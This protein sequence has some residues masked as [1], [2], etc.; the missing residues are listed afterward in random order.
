[1]DRSSGLESRV[2]VSVYLVSSSLNTH[3]FGDKVFDVLVH[4]WPIE[5]VPY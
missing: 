5:L 2:R 3:I 4:S 1:M